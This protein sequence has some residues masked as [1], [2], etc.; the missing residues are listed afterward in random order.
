MVYNRENVPQEVSMF[1]F[2]L[3]EKDG[4]FYNSFH[5]YQRV[6]NG[7]YVYVSRMLGFYTLQLYERGTASMCTLEA[8]SKDNTNDLFLLGE[9]WLL[10]YGDWDETLLRED[11]HY[12]GQPAWR[13]NCWVN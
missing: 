8:R 12:I 2:G 6:N 1:H 11:Q 13:D 10:K 9:E 3:S 7:V 5:V 4:W